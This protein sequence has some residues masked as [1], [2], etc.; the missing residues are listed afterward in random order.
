ME[1]TGEAQ[2][3]EDL[4]DILNHLSNRIYCIGETTGNEIEIR[5]E[6]DNAA[7]KIQQYLDSHKELDLNSKKEAFFG[8]AGD[9][10][11]KIINI[12]LQ[13]GCNIDE[14][15]KSG[16]TPA[17]AAAMLGN[18]STLQA[19][20]DH[21]ANIDIKSND[22]LSI[23]QYA[24]MVMDKMKGD[25]GWAKLNCIPIIVSARVRYQQGDP[26]KKCLELIK[27]KKQRNILG[28]QSTYMI[29]AGIV[30]AIVAY[31]VIKN[32]S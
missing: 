10:D 30:A 15:N 7:G 11:E 8:A 24:S 1:N 32:K 19:L 2:G 28:V 13:A 9:G 12:F 23:E 20:L 16:Q 26:F 5:K 21:G 6:L 27:F 3:E 4:S 14:K 22:L 25:D 18:V 17:M 31:Y 29:V